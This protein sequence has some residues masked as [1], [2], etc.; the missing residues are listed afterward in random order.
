VAAPRP[1][2]E[3]K[4]AVYSVDHDELTCTLELDTED[5]SIDLTREGL[6]KDILRELGLK[7][8]AQ[9]VA[10]QDPEGK[11]WPPLAKSTIKR[12]REH[13][14]GFVTG[15]MLNQGR[16]NPGT[17]T[18]EK[19]KATWGYVHDGTGSTSHGKAHGFH[20]GNPRQN[21]PARPFI[22]WPATIRNFIQELL[23]TN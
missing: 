18:V 14:I 10:G 19:R 15:A 7:L 13:K 4:I 8:Y 16:F 6:G 5:Q 21:R 3:T 1:Q 9:A 17:T 12:E 2:K 22:G 23:T 11:P 20:N